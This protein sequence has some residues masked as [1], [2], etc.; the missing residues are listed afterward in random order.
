[1]LRHRQ[2][3]LMAKRLTQLELVQCTINS[4]ELFGES[5]L[6]DGPVKYVHDVEF[7]E[8]GLPTTCH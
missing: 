8:D 5:G 3:T 7:G 6:F 1:L 4:Q 2:V